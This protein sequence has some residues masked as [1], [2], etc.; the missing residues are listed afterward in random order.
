[1]RSGI[2]CSI[3]LDSQIVE[4][5]NVSINRKTD[6]ENIIIILYGIF[7][8]PEKNIIISLLGDGIELQIMLNEI[9]PTQ[10]DK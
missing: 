1:M 10:K 4:P 9:C 7:S 2:H 8:V 3:V 5:V 6:K